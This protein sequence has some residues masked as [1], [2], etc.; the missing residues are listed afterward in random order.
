MN[1]LSNKLELVRLGLDTKYEFIV[2]IHAGCS[3]DKSEGFET[4]TQVV[5]T[6][7]KKSIVATL[8]IVTSDILK[9]N[10]ASLSEIAWQ[11]LG[12]KEGDEITISHLSPVT[13]LRH[14]RRKIYGK[15]I[16]AQGFD[17]IMRD[18]VAGKYSNIHLA[19]FITA[20]AKENLSI[21]EITNLTKAMIHTGEVLHWE[22]PFIMDKHSVGGIPGNRT[23][24]IVVAIVA[25]AG[26]IIPKTSSRA[27]TSPSG[28]ADTIETMT[29]VNIN[30]NKMRK[31][32]NKEGGCFVWGGAIGLS[33]GDDIIIKVERPLDLDSESQMIASVLSK[34]VAAGATHVVIDVPVGPTAKIRSDKTFLRLKKYFSIIG[35]ALGLNVKVLKFEG[36]QPLGIG[37]GPALEAKDILAILRNEIKLPLDL[38]NKA[39]D[40]A[41]VILEFGKKSSPGKGKEL[42]RFLLDSGAAYQKF[43]A[44]CEAQGGFCEPGSAPYTYDIT[45]KHAGLVTSIDNRTLAT[46]AKLAGAPHDPNAGIEFFAKINTSIETGQTLYRIH[47]ETKGELEYAV[48]FAYSM[49]NIVTIMRN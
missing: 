23:T 2:Y 36:I 14:V 19:S 33:P 13:S 42:A 30:I 21:N 46:L 12:A 32:V 18:I 5:V 16:S 49:P 7:K 48:A 41:G 20:C 47:A 26:L 39:I 35:T 10:Q 6:G 44:I 28:T 27:I 43:I 11:R 1:N 40:I 15:T 45:A 29:P 17:E 3:I 25:A 22:H 34:K 4:Y 8:T 9:M 24:P 31:I 37:I 38:K